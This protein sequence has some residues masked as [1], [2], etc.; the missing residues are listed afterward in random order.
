MSTIIILK[1]LAD[2]NRLEI[3]R[4]LASQAEPCASKEVV[5]SC[6]AVLE[7][8]QPTFSHHMKQLVVA[9]I[10]NEKKTGKSKYYSLNREYLDQI[11]INVDKI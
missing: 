6:S 1:A 8:S 9:N 4:H 11:G 3:V 7:L 5:P 2:E 10:V